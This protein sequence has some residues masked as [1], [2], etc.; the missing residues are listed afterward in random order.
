M[1]LNFFLF[2][3]VTLV[4]T[5]ICFRE[6]VE[7]HFSSMGHM[8][9]LYHHPKSYNI[10]RWA[11]GSWQVTSGY[12]PS[13]TSTKLHDFM[14]FIHPAG[15]M[16]C[17]CF[18]IQCPTPCPSP[19]KWQYFS[20]NTVDPF[21]V[22]S[23]SFSNFTPVVIVQRIVFIGPYVPLL[24][25]YISWLSKISL[26]Y[27]YVVSKSKLISLTLSSIPFVYATSF[28]FTYCW[29]AFGLFLDFDHFK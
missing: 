7:N 26:S 15:W 2:L 1:H 8:E 17:P 29:W 27:I 20:T 13:C 25:F 19:P 4:L 14:G 22:L 10:G 9:H 18:R 16:L 5:F 11:M 6:A 28:L 3:E 24:C 12:I 21:R 23:A